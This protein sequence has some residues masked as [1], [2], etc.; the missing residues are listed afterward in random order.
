MK[1]H[2]AHKGSSEKVSQLKWQ[3][4]VKGSACLLCFVPSHLPLPGKEHPSAWDMLGR[5]VLHQEARALLR[6]GL[7]GRDD[8]SLGAQSCPIASSCPP[9]K[10]EICLR[11]PE[12]SKGNRKTQWECVL[13]PDPRGQES[14]CIAGL[15]VCGLGRG[16]WLTCLGKAWVH[17]LFG[18]FERPLEPQSRGYECVNSNC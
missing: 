16:R 12:T 13:L 11:N 18:W 7:K 14:P 15:G 4:S 8:I 2:G 10:M 6:G 9:C 3:N 5:P 1:H 17:L